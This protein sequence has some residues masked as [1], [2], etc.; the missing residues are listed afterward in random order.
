[1]YKKPSLAGF[2][3]AKTRANFSNENPLLAN[4]VVLRT[5]LHRCL[6][7]KPSLAGFASQKHELIFQ[8]KTP[9]A[10]AVVLRTNLHLCLCTKP[11]LT[12]FATQKHELTVTKNVRGALRGRSCRRLAFFRKCFSKQNRHNHR[13]NNYQQNNWCKVFRF[14]HADS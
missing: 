11:S 13:G 12:G 7:T 6:C 10:N 3:F 9:L 2:C 4:A 8:M 5:N 14:N 1:M